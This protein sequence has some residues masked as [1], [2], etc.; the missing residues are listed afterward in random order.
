[1]SSWEASSRN[2]VFL[3]LSLQGNPLRESELL[4]F[5]T[6]ESSLTLPDKIERVDAEALRELGRTDEL[7]DDV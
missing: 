2:Q 7:E 4:E 3:P 5:L 1:M 6:S